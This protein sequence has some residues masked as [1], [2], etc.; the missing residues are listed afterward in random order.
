MEELLKYFITSG[1]LVGCLTWL[2]QHIFKLIINKDLE[3]YKNEL[4]N[5]LHN[6]TLTYKEK[7]NLYKEVGKPIIDFIVTYEH[8]QQITTDM[9]IEFDKIRLYTTTQLIMFSSSDVYDSYNELID[10]IYNCLEQKDTYSFVKLRDFSMKSLN[11]IRKDIGIH[12]DEIT[13]KGNR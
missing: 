4:Q 9:I 13:Y 5:E 8:T 10:Y 1:V 7:I 2:S 12:N 6:K 11:K 3:K